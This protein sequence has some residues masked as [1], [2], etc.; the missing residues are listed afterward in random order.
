MLTV[1][2]PEDVLVTIVRFVHFLNGSL[3]QRNRK[4]VYT[5]VRTTYEGR[6]VDEPSENT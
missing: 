1:N 5:E 6:T 4:V 2:D 3:T